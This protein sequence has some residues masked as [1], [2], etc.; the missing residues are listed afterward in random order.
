MAGLFFGNRYANVVT[1]ALAWPTVSGRLNWE[2]I[3]AV[4][5]GE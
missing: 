1:A 3:W 4:N 2:L 5:N